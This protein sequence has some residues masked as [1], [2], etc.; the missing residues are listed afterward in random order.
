MDFQIITNNPLVKEKLS[1]YP[2]QLNEALSY[3]DVLLQV[4]TKVQEGYKLLSHPLAGSVKPKETPYKSIMLSTAAG[5]GIDAGSELI[6]ENCLLLYDS[7][8]DRQRLYTE[9][10][11]ADFQYIDYTLIKSAVDSAVVI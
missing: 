5:A 8:A 4:R 9:K 7:F 3:L 1:Q 11:Q 2:V 10:V 6:I